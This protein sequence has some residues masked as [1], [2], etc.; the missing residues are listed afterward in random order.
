MYYVIIG[1]Y[2]ENKSSPPLIMAPLAG[3]T[4]S[5]CRRIVKEF[6]ADITFSEMI[7]SRGLWYKD[8]KTKELLY[9]E[10]EETPIVIQ[11]FGNEPEIMAYAAKEVLQYNP[12]GI[13][14]N[15]GCP[16]PKI[17]N[18]GDGC[19]LMKNIDLASRVCEAVAKAVDI[20][21]S[22]KFRSG[23]DEENIN[24][25]EFARAMEQSG[26]ASLTVHGRTRVQQYSGKA[27]ISVTAAVKNAVNIP[28]YHSGDITDGE[29]ALKVVNSTGCDGLMIGRGALGNPW[30][31][32]EIKAAFSG[33]EYIAPDLY[34]RIEMAK[35]HAKILCEYKGDFGGIRESRKFSAWYV[36][37]L[38]GSA[39]LRNDVTKAT[40]YM[41]LE[42]LFNEYIT[43]LKDG[44]IR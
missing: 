10:K 19:A 42:E 30:I 5:V 24:A 1:D 3:I 41:Q 21:V 6:G 25:V 27:D 40:S 44:E 18:N 32:R 36:K 33:E 20:P 43:G 23:W 17:V 26:A 38:K 29:S 22:V 39:R 4:D 7:S 37:G 14:I 2:M 8:K 9:F 16:M 13:D 11:L 31:F 34:E 12:Q 15:M 28:V 35:R